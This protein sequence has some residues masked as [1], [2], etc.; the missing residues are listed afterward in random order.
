MTP[1]KD[2]LLPCPFCGNREPGINTISKTEVTISCNTCQVTLSSDIS[3]M[4][5]KL[6]WNI[7]IPVIHPKPPHEYTPDPDPATYEGQDGWAKCSC[8]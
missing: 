7:R 5:A 1:N 6:T 2:G 8:K 3:L 4:H